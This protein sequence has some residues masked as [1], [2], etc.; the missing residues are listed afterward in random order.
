MISLSHLLATSPCW[1][2]QSQAV[3]WPRRETPKLNPGWQNQ[4]SQKLKTQGSSAFPKQTRRPNLQAHRP[5]SQ[6]VQ[7][8]LRRLVL[9]SSCWE[10]GPTQ[11]ASQ[12]GVSLF[13]TCQNYLLVLL[14]SDV[15]FWRKNSFSVWHCPSFRFCRKF[16]S[17][18]NFL[19]A[20][21]F[22]F[23]FWGI[24]FNYSSHVFPIIFSLVMCSFYWLLV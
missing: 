8:R 23:E 18:K 14:I 16:S 20:I 2:H 12:E 19:H 21:I 15:H 1:Y 10:R 24:G 4:V 3:C 5:L 11:G 17:C 9:S 22:I 6:P 7:K 13:R